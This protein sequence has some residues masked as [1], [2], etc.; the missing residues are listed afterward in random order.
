MTD[1]LGRGLRYL[2]D[3]DHDSGE[4]DAVT[5]LGYDATQPCAA[6]ISV[7]YGNLFD[8]KNTGELGPY[9]ST[10][11]T[12]R[13]YREG[14]IDPRGPGWRRNLDD[15]IQR[16]V[17]QQFRVLELD[18]R[19]AYRVADVLRAY[20]MAARAGLRVIVKNPCSSDHDETC[21]KLVSHPAACGLV[22]ERDCGSPDEVDALRRRAGC[23]GLPA[24]FVSFGRDGLEWARG[25]APRAG[26]LGMSV[27]WSRVGE[28]GSSERIT[29]GRPT[30]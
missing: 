11:D 18:N 3:R 29:D 26:Q 20:D 13:E 1:L 19:D 6:G 28:Y 25:V 15:Q 10:S 4:G 21:E 17:R 9:L 23:P 2:I 24:W 16:A 22:T 30:R 5:E 7:K 14:Q 8:E 27:S 12:A